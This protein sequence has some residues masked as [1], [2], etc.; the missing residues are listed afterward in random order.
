MTG[1]ECQL[2]LDT[3]LRQSENDGR[4]FKLKIE[5][6]VI[7]GDDDP[8]I[9]LPHNGFGYLMHCGWAARKI[10][11]SRPVK[12]VD[13]GSYLYFASVASALTPHFHYHDIRPYPMPLPGLVSTSADLMATPYGGG[14]L[15]S[16]SCLHVLEHVGLGRY[17]DQ[18]DS[19]GDV[20]A[21][22]ELSRIISPGGKLIFVIPVN[23]QPGVVWNAHRQYTYEQVLSEL[24][25][26][27]HLLEFTLITQKDV[28]VNADPRKIV[29][30]PGNVEDTGC[31]WFEKP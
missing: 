26:K 11:E 15:E 9:H 27:L 5:G 6:N 16:V 21:A 31:F 17:G 18:V 23:Q 10:A 29:S 2:K 28:I 13:F 3:F 22:R 1:P 25:P 24:F 30:H 12:H 19:M 8:G 4:N 14:M 7:L 20:K